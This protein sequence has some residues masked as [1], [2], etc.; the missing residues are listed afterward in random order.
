M[1]GGDVRIFI[2]SHRQQIM[3]AHGEG[4]LRRMVAV[5][6]LPYRPMLIVRMLILRMLILRNTPSG[7]T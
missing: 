1:G 4:C 5:T 6:I 7:Y 2:M 3:T